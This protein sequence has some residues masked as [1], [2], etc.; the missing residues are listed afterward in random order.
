MSLLLDAIRS[1][2]GERTPAQL[3]EDLGMPVA[4][5]RAQIDRLRQSGHLLPAAYRLV[6]DDRD[7]LHIVGLLPQEGGSLRWCRPEDLEVRIVAWLQRRPL[8]PGLLAASVGVDEHSG[9]FSRA[10]RWLVRHGLILDWRAP[11]P[12]EP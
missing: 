1:E 3:A 6:P 11:Y 9:T 12:E 5:V 10:C 2:P 4:E 7:P 8:S